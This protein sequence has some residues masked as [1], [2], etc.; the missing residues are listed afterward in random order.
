MLTTMITG[1][2]RTRVRLSGSM[3]AKSLPQPAKTTGE[4]PP[5]QSYG[6]GTGNYGS[7]QPW[8]VMGY[9]S[10]NQ[11]EQQC[12]VCH[13]LG[14]ISYNCPNR[15]SG[16][17]DKSSNQATSGRAQVNCCTTV[18]RMPECDENVVTKEC[19]VP[20]GKS[21]CESVCESVEIWRVSCC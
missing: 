21:V 3:P 4:Q 20:I 12:Y 9:T 13:S 14:H 6:H 1:T 2:V 17:S 19:A 15:P 5:P 7:G 16:S 11:A 10:R 18:Q 8:R